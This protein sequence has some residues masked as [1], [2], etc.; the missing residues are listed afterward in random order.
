MSLT[1]QELKELIEQEI[2]GLNTKVTSSD[3]D[4]CI[5]DALRQTGWTL[6]VSTSFREYWVKQRSKRELFFYLWTEASHKFKFEGINL[7]HRFDHYKEIIKY[8]DEQFEA[9]MEANVH[10]FANAEAYQLFGQKLDAGF[11]YDITGR[12]ITYS[13]KNRVILSPDESD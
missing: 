2:K 5:A 3:I 12:D 11:S 8:M 10:E 1:E 13:S 9:A 4:N 6:P 7:Q